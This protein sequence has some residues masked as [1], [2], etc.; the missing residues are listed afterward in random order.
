MMTKSEKI[1]KMAQDGA[2]A[3]DIAKKVGCHQS[4]VYIVLH[5]KNKTNIVLHRKNKTKDAAPTDQPV[6]TEEPKPWIGSVGQLIR[7]VEMEL[8]K[9]EQEARELSHFLSRLKERVDAA[10]V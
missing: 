7:D 6:G 10:S 4:Y 3:K 8:A 5:R 1:L 9:K 2:N